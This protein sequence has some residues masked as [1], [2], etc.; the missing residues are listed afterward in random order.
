MLNNEPVYQRLLP[1]PPG[2]PGG[3]QCSFR[4]PER[5]GG[6][7][8][9]RVV[10]GKVVATTSRPIRPFPGRAGTLALAAVLFVLIA[11]AALL[12]IWWWLPARVV[13]TPARITRAGVVF[14]QATLAAGEQA[15]IK[16]RPLL[17]HAQSR[18]PVRVEATGRNTRPARRAAGVLTWYN[19]EPYPQRVAQ[20]AVL[21]VTP[22]LTL[23]TDQEVVI[24]S[25]HPPGLGVASGW[26]HAGAAGTSGNIPAGRLNRLCACGTTAVVVK[27]LSPFTG[28]QDRTTITT[29]TTADVE[30]AIKE[31]QG[32]LLG[33]AR[34]HLHALLAAPDEEMAPAS[35][36]TGAVAQPA[37]GSA[38]ASTAVVIHVTCAALAYHRFV[39]EREAILRLATSSKAS[40]Y[41]LLRIAATIKRAL[42]FHNQGS[43]TFTVL[44]KGTWVYQLTPTDLQAIQQQVAGKTRAQ[45]HRVLAH[46]PAIAAFSIEQVIPW[47]PLPGDPEHIAVQ[48]MS[49]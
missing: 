13:I 23:V 30:R 9:A 20:G 32:Q 18:L 33:Q 27:N 37:V 41:R 45:A 17:A 34:A 43:L 16:L 42:A 2:Q 44:V 25:A 19:Q 6:A 40:R 24:P 35:C 8:A 39:V 26:A 31:Q 28:G 1:A 15:P 14:L 36:A 3:E 38:A 46:L 11:G 4:T 12:G 48:C 7:R 10:E 29:I 49:P 47:L 21:A 22:S 5:L